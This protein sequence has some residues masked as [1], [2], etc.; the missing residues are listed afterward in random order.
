MDLAAQQVGQ[1]AADRQPQAGAAV[2][3][4][5]A[6]IGLLERLEDDSLLVQRNADAGIGDLE[7]NHRCRAA[8]D[9]MVF[10]PTGRWRRKR[11]SARR[12]AR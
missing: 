10:A 8:Q 7:R 1:F 11:T 6:G 3:A 2:F 12:L 4:A 5:G 9:R